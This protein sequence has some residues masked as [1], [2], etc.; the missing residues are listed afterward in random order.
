MLSLRG[1]VDISF[2]TFPVLLLCDPFPNIPWVDK[3]IICFFFNPRPSSPWCNTGISKSKGKSLPRLKA[4]CEGSIF[5]YRS[6]NVRRRSRIL[7]MSRTPTSCSKRSFSITWCSQSFKLTYGNPGLL[8]RSVLEILISGACPNRRKTWWAPDSLLPSFTFDKAFTPLVFTRVT[9]AWRMVSLQETLA[10]SE[11][12]VQMGLIHAW[13]IQRE[14]HIE[15]DYLKITHIVY[16]WSF[17]QVASDSCRRRATPPLSQQHRK[18]RVI[19]HSNLPENFAQDSH[20]CE[21]I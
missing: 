17:D 13:Q 12:A 9:L 11:D 2:A 18:V 5:L 7:L 21:N 3:T 10:R 19:A 1:S 16:V 14:I 20:M 8:G 4:T 6:Q 15:T